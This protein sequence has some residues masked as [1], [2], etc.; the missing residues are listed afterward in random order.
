MKTKT[1]RDREEEEIGGGELQGRRQEA[2]RGW[3]SGDRAEKEMRWQ[4]EGGRS[5]VRGPR[6]EAHLPSPSPAHGGGQ[7]G[8]A[9]EGPQWAA[10]KQRGVRYQRAQKSKG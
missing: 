2:K 10:L 3:R 9:G 7:A 6:A 5:E 4:L 8:T 1:R